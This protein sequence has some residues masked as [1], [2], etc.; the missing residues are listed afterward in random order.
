MWVTLQFGSK[1]FGKNFS[2]AKILAH[3]ST[4]VKFVSGTL[5]AI[6]NSSGGGL[7]LSQTGCQP[8]NIQNLNKI[9]I[10]KISCL[11]NLPSSTNLPWTE[12]KWLKSD[13]E[14]LIM[15]LTDL[16]SVI[17]SLFCVMSLFGSVSIQ[18]ASSSKCFDNWFQ[19]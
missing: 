5:N 15:V 10:G 3:T 7:F 6:L 9:F 2:G 13:N 18:L 16:I 1:N 8:L 12:E 19:S 14:I 17:W 4:F 11:N